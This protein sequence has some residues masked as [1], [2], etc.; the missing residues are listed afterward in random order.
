M[1]L[2][3]GGWRAQAVDDE[4]AKKDQAGTLRTVCRLDADGEVGSSL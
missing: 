4:A 3:G 2:D 1:V